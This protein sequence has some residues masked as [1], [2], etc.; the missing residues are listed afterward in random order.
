MKS[1]EI[2][3][4]TNEETQIYYKKSLKLF[5]DFFLFY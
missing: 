2:P 4:F 3:F 1:G 5:S